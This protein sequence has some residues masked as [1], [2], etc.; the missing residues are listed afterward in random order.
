MININ[1]DYHDKSFQASIHPPPT[2]ENLTK[3]YEKISILNPI[4]SLRKWKWKLKNENLVW[5]R[6]IIWKHI[7]NPWKILRLAFKFVATLFFK[8]H[9]SC[10]SQSWI[11]CVYCLLTPMEPWSGVYFMGVELPSYSYFLFYMGI[12]SAESS[13]SLGFF[14]NPFPFPFFSFLQTHMPI[15]Q[16]Q[17]D[18]L[19][20]SLCFILIL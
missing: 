8:A 3:C 12:N 17:W 16:L 14:P 1:E 20:R 2:P 13:I 5:F 15:A 18:N 4:C 19:E 10:Y 11:F 6:I 7:L 9:S